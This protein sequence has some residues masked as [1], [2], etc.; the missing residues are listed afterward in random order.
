MKQRILLPILL[1]VAVLGTSC[2]SQ[3]NVERNYSEFK[4]DQV[5]LYMTM[6]DY[7]YLGDVTV[8]VEYTTYLGIFRKIKTVNGEPYDPR[9]YHVTNIGFRGNINR[10]LGALKKAL[11]KV[12]ETY[13][14]A[15]YIMPASYNDVVEHMFGGRTHKRSMVV[16]VYAVDKQSAEASQQQHEN[17]LK[18][19]EQQKAALQQQVSELSAELKNTKDELEKAQLDAR[20]NAQKN[21]RTRR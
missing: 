18:A 16:K 17:E 9:F 19:V 6:A 12:T 15:D 2:V 1:F 4:P 14:N 7:Q 20:I 3:H 8:D 5:R 13:P 10:K 21:N 11:Y